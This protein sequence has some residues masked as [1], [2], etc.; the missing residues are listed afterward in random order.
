MP[1]PMNRTAKRLGNVLPH[2]GSDSSQGSA[3]AT[4][5]PRSTV[6]LEIPLMHSPRAC[7]AALARKRTGLCLVRSV[8]VFLAHVHSGGGR[9]FTHTGDGAWA[10]TPDG[11]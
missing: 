6:R 3:T 9:N 10:K 4:P 1:L 2:A 7:S 5:T 11:F 8:V